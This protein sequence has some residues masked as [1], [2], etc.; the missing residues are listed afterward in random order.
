MKRILI[1]GSGGAGKSTLAVKLQKILQLPLIHLDS[2]Y[3]NA[4]W[5][6]SSKADWELK[7]KELVQRETWIMDGNYSG[8]L[9]LRLPRADTVIFLDFPNWKCVW[10]AL[11]RAVRYHGTTRSDMAVGCPEKV[12][13][14]FLVY[15]WNYP[16]RSRPK[17]M[18]M[19][20][21]EKERLEVFVLKSDEEVEA[22]LEGCTK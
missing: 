22:F 6:E 19:L 3:W 16:K 13:W 14:E 17:V 10:R 11:W 12:D 2:R 18:H 8:S 4:G 7:V 9:H 1:L 5:V 15:L 21:G 20:E